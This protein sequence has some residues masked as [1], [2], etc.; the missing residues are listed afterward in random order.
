MLELTVRTY[1]ENLLLELTGWTPVRTYPSFLFEFSLLF[2]FPFSLS[3]HSRSHYHSCS[4]SFSHANS[5]YPSHSHSHFYSHSHSPSHS[6]SQSPF[7]S[8]SLSSSMFH[9]VLWSTFES[10]ISFFRSAG[11]PFPQNGVIAVKLINF[12]ICSIAIQS[13]RSHKFQNLLYKSSKTGHRFKNEPE[14]GQAAWNRLLGGND[15]WC[16]G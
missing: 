2:S 8:P 10:N 5:H 4:Y 3:F 15:W 9:N 1:C 16:E 6:P 13:H 7:P 11:E 12:K 14:R